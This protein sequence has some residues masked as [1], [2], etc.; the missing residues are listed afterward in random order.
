ME[1]PE[2]PEELMTIKMLAKFMRVGPASC[3]RLLKKDPTFPRIKFMSDYRFRR[4]SIE[5]WLAKQ[6]QGT[7]ANAGG[8]KK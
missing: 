8:A 2:S 6:E 5:A 3:Y 7:Q 1:S 4:S